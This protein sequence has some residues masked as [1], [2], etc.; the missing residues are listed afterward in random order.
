MDV[1]GLVYYNNSEG[2]RIRSI[3]FQKLFFFFK[4]S[5]GIRQYFRP[6]TPFPSRKDTGIRALAT[7]EA[8]GSVKRVLEKQARQQSGKKRK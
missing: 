4:I 2:D 3:V 1:S 5:T 8:N 6:T 7:H